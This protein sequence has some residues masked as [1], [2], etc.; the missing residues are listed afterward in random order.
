M[1]KQK[2]PL[3]GRAVEQH[4][5]LPNQAHLY[6]AGRLFGVTLTNGRKVK[7]CYV[8][9]WWINGEWY[10]REPLPSELPQ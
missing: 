4:L 2:F 6:L 5:E 1:S 7:G 8:M 3:F 9:R 10:Y